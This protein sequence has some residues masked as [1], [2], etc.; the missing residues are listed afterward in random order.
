MSVNPI[1]DPIARYQG[2][3]ADAI[4]LG[5]RIRAMADSG[6]RDY[7]PITAHRLE[8]MAHLAAAIVFSTKARLDD[9]ARG[10]G[11]G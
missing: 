1:P 8:T 2:L 10:G 11:E 9:L 5:K 6:V 3:Q 7:D 4:A